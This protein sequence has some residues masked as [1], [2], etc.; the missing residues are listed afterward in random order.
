VKDET[1]PDGSTV[2]AGEKVMKT[3]L[4]Q[5]TGKSYWPRGTKLVFV[6]GQLRPVDD[7][8][9]PMVPSAAPQEIVEVSVKLDVPPIPGRYVGYYRLCHGP[10]NTAFGTR[11]WVD[12]VVADKPLEALLN[13]G[14]TK[15][16]KAY[17]SARKA[18]IDVLKPSASSA[19]PAS[20]DRPAAPAVT[21]KPIQPAQPVSAIVPAPSVP[22]VVD[23]SDAKSRPVET[24]PEWICGTCTY[25]N[26]S[27]VRRC[28]LCGT[29]QSRPASVPA[30]VPVQAPLIVSV[31]APAPDSA[32]TPAPV[33]V[34]APAPVST[35]APAL[36]PAPTPAPA[37]PAPAAP[38]APVPAP[39]APVPAPAPA[40]PAPVPAPVPA[41]AA[42]VPSPAP[43]P[44]VA[45]SAAVVPKDGKAAAPEQPPFQYAAELRQVIDFGFTKE[46]TIKEYLMATK[47]NGSPELSA[48]RNAA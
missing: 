13:N 37:A 15:I 43:A 14:L 27:N 39:E 44:A 29:R 34:P 17:E 5:N 28:T 38:V 45:P 48:L 12:V 2:V 32:P 18:V 10:E 36:D 26:N 42:P 23:S 21:P 8:E 3:W 11:V 31:P 41:P 47:G 7:E 1:I 4:L 40:A 46:D 22:G 6:G 35:P 19:L 16:T 30:E 33:P 9:P 20:S 24:L 25:S